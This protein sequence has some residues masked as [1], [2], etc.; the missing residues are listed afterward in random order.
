[1]KKV[2]GAAAFTAALIAVNTTGIV[3]AAGPQ[4]S[5]G[6]AQGIGRFEGNVSS[7]VFDVEVPILPEDDS[8]YASEVSFILDPND[9]IKRT[10]AAKYAGDTFADSAKGV[11]FKNKDA[12]DTYSGKS[13]KITAVNKGTNDVNVSV[14]AELIDYTGITLQETKPADWTTIETAG[15]YMAVTKDETTPDPKVIKEVDSVASAAL[16][17]SLSGLDTNGFDLTYTEEGGYQ[18]VIP[19]TATYE[20]Y[21]FYVEGESGGDWSAI[22]ASIAP[23]LDL[24]WN[25]KEDIGNVDPGIDGNP[26]SLTLTSA[27]DTTVTLN[28]GAGEYE[29]TGVTGIT[30]SVPSKAAFN[31]KDLDWLVS[32]NYVAVDNESGLITVKKAFAAALSDAGVAGGSFSITFNNTKDS[33]GDY[34]TTVDIPFTV[35]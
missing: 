6:G 22:S 2:K 30:L 24:V 28:Y 27:S 13:D 7:N 9:L 11:Y 29:A 10:S 23:K 17:D 1:M 12:Y 19:E 3:F 16:T 8:G 26:A 35:G 21:S 20:S 34:P 14:K 18:Y 15:L 32:N 31:N 25:F 5:G 4:Q 33:T